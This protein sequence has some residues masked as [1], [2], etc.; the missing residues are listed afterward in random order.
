[1]LS[2]VEFP[3]VI[4]YKTNVLIIIRVPHHEVEAFVLIPARDKFTRNHKAPK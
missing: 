1:M 2:I 4:K 3:L